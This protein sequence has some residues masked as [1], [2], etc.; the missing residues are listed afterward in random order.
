MILCSIRLELLALAL[1]CA[2]TICRADDVMPPA[3]TSSIAGRNE[4]NGD[5]LTLWYPAPAQQWT[6]A[7]AIGNGRL[8]A[9]VFGIPD[10]ERQ[11]LNDVTVWSGGPQPDQ[12]RA[13]AYEA[14]S[15]IRDALQSG[16]Y[17]KADKLT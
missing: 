8:G 15:D 11:Q 12:N 1:I 10:H 13:N 17:A 9:M 5:P 7:L 14:L 2:V 16:D 4:G 3:A 6:N